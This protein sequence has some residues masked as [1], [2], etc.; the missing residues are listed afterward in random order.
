M[1]M[2]DKNSPIP[3]YF[4]LRETIQEMIN[5]GELTPGS[6]IPSEREYAEKFQVSRM[7]IRH[8][9][10]QLVN[11][12]YLYRIQGKGTFVAER[13]KVEQP[14]LGL[15]SFTEDMIARGMIPG[16]K[17]I[18]YTIIPSDKAMAK[19][20]SIQEHGPVYEIKRIRLADGLPMAIE[21]NYLPANLVK[22]LT[23]EI[24][25]KSL[26]SYI[27]ERLK[28]KIDHTSQVIES[29]VADLVESKYLHIKK[30][31]PVLHIQRHSFLADG[32]P[33][34]LVKYVYRADRY[35]FT[36]KMNR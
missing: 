3:I 14:N 27:E 17:L 12:D 23:E 31:A 7:T 25:S 11:S 10:T 9:I 19:Q 6:A 28:L 32:T 33:F 8:A 2:I 26:Y 22:G 20:L 29:S 13:K 35:K 16:S 21:T 24:I 15:M 30:G 34:E 4:Q 1:D 36:L 18:N 5:R